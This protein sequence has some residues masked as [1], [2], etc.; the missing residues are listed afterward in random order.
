[1]L[2]QYYPQVL[3]TGKPQ[4]A[5]AGEGKGCGAGSQ[6]SAGRGDPLRRLFDRLQKWGSGSAPEALRKL[7]G[8][9][10]SPRAGTTGS[11]IRSNP[12]RQGR[13]DGAARAG[14]IAPPGRVRFCGE[15]GGCARSSLHHRLIS[16]V[17]PGQRPAGVRRLARRRRRLETATCKER[18]GGF[19]ENPAVILNGVRHGQRRRRGAAAPHSK[20]QAR[21]GRRAGGRAARC[22][23]A[24]CRGACICRS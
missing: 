6:G 15:S 12:P 10:A 11:W 18:G 14:S 22:E 8:G 13:W 23:S 16:D 9:A 19:V 3:I 21:A 17:P 20:T 2:P 7:A 1:M 5:A 4:R 24:R